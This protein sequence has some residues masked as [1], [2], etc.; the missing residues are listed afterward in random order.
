MNFDPNWGQAGQS[1]QQFWQEQWS[2]SLQTLQQWGTA[3]PAG[4]GPIP[5]M[6][7]MPGMP[8]MG[9]APNPWAGIMDAMQS[10]MPQGGGAS[11]VQ[12]DPAKLKGLQEEYLAAVQSLTDQKAVQALLGKDKRFNTP[13]WAANPVAAVAAANFLVGSRMLMGM[14]DAVQSDEK[15]CNRLRFAV[16]QWVA[17]MA[18]SNFLALNADAL[19]KV[20]ETKGESL[21]QGISNLLADMRQGHVSMTDE[22]LFTVGKNVATTEGAVVFENELFQ[23]IEYKPL[24]TKVYEKPFLMVPPCINKF[25]ILDLQP[26]NSVI[27]YAV[28]EGHHTFVVSWRNPDES[29][30]HKSWD[31]TCTAAMLGW[32]RAI[33]FGLGLGS[34]L[35]LEGFYILFLGVVAVVIVLI[36]LTAVAHPGVGSHRLGV[37]VFL[38]FDH[39]GQCQ[40]A[41]CLQRISRHGAGVQPFHANH[42]SI[43]TQAL[44]QLTMPHIHANDLGRILLQQAVGKTARALTHIQTAQARDFEA[45]GR[46][47][48][49]Q[50]EPAARDVFGLCRIQQQKLCTCGNIVAIL[51]N[52][53]PGRQRR[54]TPLHARSN[55]A[56]RLRTRGS[57]TRFNQKHICA[58]SVASFEINRR[59]ALHGVQRAKKSF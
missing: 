19:H 56:L 35:G 26:D 6:P 44:M 45:G 18:P 7:T 2:K 21:A 9:G 46:Q 53:L 30:A 8:G 59:Q 40:I 41:S 10:A 29:L 32:H 27:R 1:I 5:S 48:A 4:F 14:A 3:A 13:E 39:L 49:F 24:T 57:M 55:Q 33:R 50:L 54:E 15:T 52:L 16:E 22:T 47:S 43:G 37:V 20:V 42:A 31:C 25:Y 51:G 12:F 23:L 28:S 11:T 58:H 17:A 34:A 38:L 36:D